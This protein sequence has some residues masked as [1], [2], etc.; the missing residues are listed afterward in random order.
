MRTVRRYVPKLAMKHVV[1]PRTAR[2]LLISDC[3]IYGQSLKYRCVGDQTMPAND[4]SELIAESSKGFLDEQVAD[5]DTRKFPR[6]DLQMLPM[7]TIHPVA[8]LGSETQECFVLIRN[9]SNGGVSF[10]HPKQ[11]ALG[12]RVDLAFEDGKDVQAIVLRADRLAPRCFEI[13]CRLVGL[14]NKAK[15]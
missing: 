15:P 4:Q 14:K 3:T 1:Q 12:Q 8:T 2:K 7:A 6:F 11:L 5:L 9:V 10:L 13:G